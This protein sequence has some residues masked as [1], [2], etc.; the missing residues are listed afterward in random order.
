METIGILQALSAASNVQNLSDEQYQ[1]VL[2]ELEGFECWD[3]WF[4]AVRLHARAH[5]DAF[6]DDYRRLARAYLTYFDDVKGA[7]ECCRA[8]V[9][10]SGMAFTRFRADV[11]SRILDQDDFAAEGEILQAVW[12]RFS[13]VDDRIAALERMC[14]IYEK[15][16]H[17]ESLLNEF[18]QKL[19]KIS[20]DNGKALRYFRALNVQIQ[21]WPAVVAILNRLYASAKHPQ[22][23]FRYAQELAAIHLY[24]LDDP[25]TAIKVIEERCSNSTLDTSTIH[26]EAYYRLGKFDGCLRVL[27]SC[28]ANVDNDETKAVIHYRIASLYEQ[29]GQYQ[30]AIENFER[31]LQL[32]GRFLEAMEG[33]VSTSLKLKDWTKVKEW[34]A[35]LSSGVSSRALADQLRAGLVRLEEG[36]KGAVV[37]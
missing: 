15:K 12:E 4:A 24:Q 23:G 19:L 26:Y 25:N 35:V 9:E 29:Q 14:F 22:E 31:T 5:P 11:L 3:P 1:A 27:R 2:S 16:H 30:L 17:I 18:Y 20:P 34:L 7:A 28:L 8:I 6:I 21:D 36:M 10:S 13:A 32:Q 33:L 37:S